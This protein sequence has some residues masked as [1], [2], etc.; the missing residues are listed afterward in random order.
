MICS[1]TAAISSITKRVRTPRDIRLSTSSRCLLAASA[2]SSIEAA[3]A[4]ASVKT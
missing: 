4:I 3:R 1:L 2:S